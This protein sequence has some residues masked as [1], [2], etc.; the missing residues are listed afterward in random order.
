MEDKVTLCYTCKVEYKHRNLH[1]CVKCC[2]SPW[3]QHCGAKGCG[4]E[5]DHI[6]KFFV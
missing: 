1:D 5:L 4:G 3:C 2:T 6:N